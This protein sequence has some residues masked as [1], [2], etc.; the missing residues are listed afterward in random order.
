VD[1]F[2]EAHEIK[3]IEGEKRMKYA[4]RGRLGTYSFLVGFAGRLGRD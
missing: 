4:A 2:V 3:Q 1:S